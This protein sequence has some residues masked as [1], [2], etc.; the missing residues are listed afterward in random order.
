MSSTN[1]S[2][3]R[4]ERGLRD[5][6]PSLAPEGSGA[7][8][9][10]ISHL[11]DLIVESW[12]DLDAYGGRRSH[13]YYTEGGVFDFAGQTTQGREPIREL[14]TQRRE[15]GARTTMHFLSNFVGEVTDCGAVVRYYICVFAADGEPLQESGRPNLIGY[16]QDEFEHDAQEGWLIAHRTFR[17]V[18]ASS[19]DRVG[20]GVLQL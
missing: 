13:K 8:L 15:A 4:P 10:L 14:F 11:E 9:A 16:M 3:G 19:E 2:S 1:G 18:L 6:R 17:P 20:R 12:W 5:K 7:G